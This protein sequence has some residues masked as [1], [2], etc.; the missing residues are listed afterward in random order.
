VN[1]LRP[2]MWLPHLAFQRDL[3]HFSLITYFT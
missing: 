1:N 2:T 3:N